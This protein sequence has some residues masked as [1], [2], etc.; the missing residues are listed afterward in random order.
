[1]NNSRYNI[2]YK[3]IQKAVVVDRGGGGSLKIELSLIFIRC[4]VSLNVTFIIIIPLFNQ[5]L[6][7]ASTALGVISELPLWGDV[8]KI[9]HS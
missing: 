3:R 1:M 6:T 2:R 4:F 7:N 5:K 9:L 8:N